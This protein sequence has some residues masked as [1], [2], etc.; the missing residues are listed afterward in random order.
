MEVVILAIQEV[1]K[2][3]ISFSLALVAKSTIIT[4]YFVNYPLLK[5]LPFKFVNRLTLQY[6]VNHLNL[7][8]SSF[9]AIKTTGFT[10]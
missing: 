3:F 1:I 7:T 4:P 2:P 8:A 9:T 10:D 5:Y 6:L